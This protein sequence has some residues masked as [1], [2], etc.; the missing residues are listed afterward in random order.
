ML[1]QQICPIHICEAGN[2]YLSRQVPRD[3][4]RH[5]KADLIMYSLWTRLPPLAASRTPRAAQQLDEHWYHLLHIGGDGDIRL[6]PRS[7]I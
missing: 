4:S 7:V 6:E 2:L 1:E 3:L 5:Y